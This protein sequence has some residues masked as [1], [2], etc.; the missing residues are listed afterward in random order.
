M[1]SP[2]RV[3]LIGL[4]CVPPKLLFDWY[5]GDM[6][7]MAS[8][9][10]RA[11]WGPLAS[12]VPPITVPAWSCMLSGRTPGELGVYG[13]RN[14]RD[15]RY[16]RSAF[17]T[18]DWIQVPRVW[19]LVGAAGG[20][21]IVL[22]VPGTYP[23]SPISGH[24]VSCFLAPST[25]AAFTH[26]PGL[27]EEVQRATGGYVLDVADFRNCPPASA[28]QR[29]FDMTEQRFE[30]AAHLASSHPWDFMAFVDMGP[31]RLHHV[32]WQHCDPA[33]PKHEP[34]NALSGV[35][36]EYYRA[37]DRHLGR[38]LEVVP[39]DAAVLVVSD[40][41]AQPMLGGFRFNQW[42][43]DQ[44]LLV[45]RGEPRPGRLDPALVDWPRTTAWGDGGY[46][47][48]LFLNVKGRE[49]QG[50]VPPDRYEAVRQ[51]LADALRA[52]PDH[53][54]VPMGT[55]VFR[56]EEV[57]PEVRNIAP[58]L[59]V[60]FGNLRWRAIGSLEPGGSLCTFDN[61]TGPDG[62][63]HAEDGVFVLA[64]DGLGGGRR[65]G[66]S[67]YDVAP[68]LQSLLGLPAPPAQRGQVVA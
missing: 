64:A 45:L 40:H 54:G 67:I 49:P 30:L 62:A 15:H 60:Y 63:N 12:T 21:S 43:V 27:R 26:P 22:G 50:V 41:G 23:P 29:V 42:L 37:L 17:A 19:D 32:L 9:R 5:A 51:E 6:P 1:S 58:D 2:R 57:Y 56:P 10:G 20:Q 55:R 31:D 8:L 44:G 18:S 3:V 33:H 28:A 7:T 46:Y 68:T 59:I 36:R 24:M 13:F 61:D 14:R 53:T 38:F 52:L 25:D 47:G 48:R 39:D 4:D 35:F 66:L 16:D 65:D 11:V 34:G